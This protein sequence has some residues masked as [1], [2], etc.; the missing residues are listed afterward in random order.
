MGKYPN[1]DIHNKYSDFHWGL[2]KNGEQYKKLYTCDID[3]LWIEYDFKNEEIVGVLDIKWDDNGDTLTPTENGV[4]KWFNKNDIRVFIVFI[5]RLFTKFR[6][7]NEKGNEKLFNKIQ[8]ADFL[9]SLR[10]KKLLINFMN[11]YEGY[12]ELDESQFSLEL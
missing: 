5:D 11:K 7:V 6:V 3:R 9:L 12:K 10:N 8:Y 2:I 1:S 4:Y